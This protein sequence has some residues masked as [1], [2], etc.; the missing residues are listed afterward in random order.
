MLAGSNASSCACSSS[1]VRQ[2]IFLFLDME[3]AF[4]RVSYEFTNQGMYWCTLPIARS[5]KSW[6]F[7]FNNSTDKR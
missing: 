5:L 1:G 2:G 4:D 3:K 6:F 7:C